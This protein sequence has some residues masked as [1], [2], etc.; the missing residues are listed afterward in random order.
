VPVR[1]LSFDL[2]DTLVDLHMD[3]LPI[4]EIAGRRFPSTYGLLHAASLQWHALDFE[5]FAAELGEHDRALRGE[6]YAKQRELPTLLRFRTFAERIG[7]PD[8][9]LAQ[10]LTETHMAEVVRQVV[11][12]AHHAPLLERL[13]RRVKLAV[14]SNF[15]HSTTARAVLER[16]GLLA[17]FDAVVISE[18][19]GLRKPR[20]EIFDAVAERLAVPQAEI[21]HI[22]DNLDAD[23][24]GAAAVGQKTVWLTRRVSDP[25]SAL[26]G[27]D[28]VRPDHAIADLADLE[29][30]LAR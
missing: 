11:Y 28:G 9:A 20:A 30:W 15:S 22:G 27:Y 6:Y 5:R 26:N 17:H 13:H 16:A 14:C 18:D 24:A 23:I 3:R 2:F 7:V 1:A 10:A 8:E 4:V 21:A 19:V 25:D 12:L 29:A